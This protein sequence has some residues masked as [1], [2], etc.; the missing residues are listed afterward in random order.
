MNI[1]NNRLYDGDTAL[2]AMRKAMKAGDHVEAVPTMLQGA[3]KKALRGRA[4]ATISKT[5]GG[6]LSKW[7]A[8]RR[9]ARRKMEKET[10]RKQRR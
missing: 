5:S 1:D 2:E 8:G 4:E 7:A 6:K 3:A 9:K 10:R